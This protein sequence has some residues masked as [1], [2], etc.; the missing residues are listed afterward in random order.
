VFALTGSGYYLGGERLRLGTARAFDP[1]VDGLM[2]F[3]VVLLKT[4]EMA[5]FRVQLYPKP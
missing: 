2:E 1:I 5:V 4:A 3:L